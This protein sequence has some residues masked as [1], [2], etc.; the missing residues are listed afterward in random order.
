MIACHCYSLRVAKFDLLASIVPTRSGEFLVMVSSVPRPAWTARSE[1]DEA[2]VKTRA[3]ADELC[4]RLI[5]NARI[6]LQSRG[7]QITEVI[8]PGWKP[9]SAGGGDPIR[10]S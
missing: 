3:E 8:G 2:I 1:L 6:R 10:R 5:V 4:S 9:G 7:D